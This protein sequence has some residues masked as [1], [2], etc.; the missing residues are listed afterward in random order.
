[1]MAFARLAPAVLAV[2]AACSDATVEAVRAKPTTGAPVRLPIEVIGPSGTERSIDLQIPDGSVGA[3]LWLQVHNLHRGRSLRVAVNDADFV[4]AD[5]DVA[6][7]LEPDKGAGGIAGGF[8]TVRFTLPLMPGAMRDGLNR[9]RFR[10]ETTDGWGIGVRI[11]AMNVLAPDGRRLLGDEAFVTDHPSEWRP[12]RSAPADIE[13]GATLWRRAK[14]VDPTNGTPMQATCGGCH[15]RD[16]RDLQYF[17]YS[18]AAIVEM[19]RRLGLTVDEGELV[20]S[21]VRSLPVASLGRP[22]NPPYQPGPDLDARPI[23]AWAAGAGVEWVLPDDRASIP[24]AFPDGIRA[25]A[26]ATNRTIALHAI[27]IAMQLPDWNRWLPRRHPSDAFA[28]FATS[29]L[30]VGYDGAA[31]EVPASESLRGQLEQN[32]VDLGKLAPQIEQWLRD[33]GS[34]VA[35]LRGAP[36]DLLASRRWRVVKTFELLTTFRL[37]GLAPSLYGSAAIARMWFPLVPVVAD[38]APEPFHGDRTAFDGSLLT[39]TYA[40]NAWHEL[41]VILQSGSRVQRGYEPVIWPASLGYFGDLMRSSRRGEPVRFLL[42]LVRASQDTDRAGPPGAAGWSL[43]HARLWLLAEDDWVRGL[44]R[45]PEDA[46]LRRALVEAYL[47]NWQ[48]RNDSFQPGDWPRCKSVCGDFTL[49]DSSYRP[50]VN[51]GP[52]GALPDIVMRMIVVFRG[53]N[54]SCA[55]LN[56]F[57]AWGA[58]LWPLGDWQSLT[59]ACP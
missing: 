7:V 29:S 59:V 10:Y 51:G 49:P 22:W 45:D 48:A 56:D 50:V 18:D 27:P 46:G 6:D 26:I 53:W 31:G 4:R 44:W 57:A 16:G 35:G 17:A 19:A 8:S 5:N 20:A 15:L 37:E 39:W 38:G 41:A 24:Y 36:E 14:L 47:T 58:S 42:N 9:V 40:T 28:A 12:L 52:T 23:E 32:V 3:K 13:R 11:V 55:L 2:L 30:A 43:G 1:M 21:Y 25:E 34:F 54:V 33:G